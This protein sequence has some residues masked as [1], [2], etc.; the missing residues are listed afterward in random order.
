MSLFGWKMNFKLY[1]SYLSFNCICFL[2]CK[3]RCLFSYSVRYYLDG[4]IGIT[5]SSSFSVVAITVMSFAK[6]MISSLTLI[7]IDYRTINSTKWGSEWILVGPFINS[8]GL[9]YPAFNKIR[10]SETYPLMGFR[11]LLAIFLLKPHEALLNASLISKVIITHSFRCLV[12]K[13]A[14]PFDILILFDGIYSLFALSKAV[15]PYRPFLLH[16]CWALLG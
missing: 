14:T 4:Y 3:P 13:F 9:G 11:R 2:R 1:V 16:F 5:N 8:S 12:G 7:W 15:L 6:P 10:L